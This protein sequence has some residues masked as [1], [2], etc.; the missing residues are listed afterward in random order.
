MEIV[1]FLLR[2]W[3]AGEV[4]AAGTSSSSSSNSSSG[5]SSKKKQQQQ[6]QKVDGLSLLLQH[7]SVARAA[8]VQQTR[9]RHGRFGGGLLVTG[10]WYVHSLPPSLPSSLPSSLTI[11]FSSPS[12]SF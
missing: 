1:F 8:V 2:G 4:A 11:V 5:S 7:E 6:K 10:R 3:D 12:P 9:S